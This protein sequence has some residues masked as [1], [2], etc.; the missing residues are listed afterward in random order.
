MQSLRFIEALA[1]NA[2]VL[3]ET[4]YDVYDTATDETH[5]YANDKKSNW[6]W[7]EPKVW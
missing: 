2:V 3:N 4:L 1:K 5:D 6:S 7:L